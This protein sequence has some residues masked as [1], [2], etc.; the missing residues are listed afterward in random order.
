MQKSLLTNSFVSHKSKN[1]SGKLANAETS[2]I[3]PQDSLNQSQN[4]NSIKKYKQ[5]IRNQ[6]IGQ[7]PQKFPQK[8]NSNNIYIQI[9]E[10]KQFKSWNSANLNAIYQNIL[11]TDKENYLDLKPNFS[12]HLNIEEIHRTILVDWLIN[13]HLYFKLN[14]ECLYLTIKLIDSFLARTKNIS[15]TKLQLLGICSLQVSS[16]YIE[17]IHPTIKDLIELCE[18]CYTKKEIINFEKNLLQTNNYIIEQ[19]QIINYYDLISLIL[20]LNVICYFFGKMLLDFTLLDVNFYQYQKR[21][22]IFSVLFLVLNNLEMINNMADNLDDFISE[23][24]NG[25]NKLRINI[26]NFDSNIYYLF[27]FYPKK[28][29]ELIFKCSE[30]IR[31]LFE[32]MSMNK[33]NSA[34]QKYFVILK[35]IKENGIENENEDSSYEESEDFEMVII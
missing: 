27:S 18:K 2:S 7:K 15:K 23:S 26:N 21:T 30:E 24:K 31:N 5:N 8:Q 3:S 19:D 34:L 6:K 22:I 11:T 14:D 4:S 32:K 1:S 16:K 12:N 10:L 13:V 17:L 29:Y 20:K 28:N 33:Y 9:N 25:K 35:E